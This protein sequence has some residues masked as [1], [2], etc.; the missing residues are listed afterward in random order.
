[1][2]VNKANL[3]TI[4]DNTSLQTPVV[5]EYSQEM[6]HCAQDPEYTPCNGTTPLVIPARPTVASGALPENRTRKR[7]HGTFVYD[8]DTES[9]VTSASD[10]EALFSDDELASLL[11]PPRPPHPTDYIPDTLE[12]STL[13][14]L[15]PPSYATSRASKRLSTDLASIIKFQSSTAPHELGFHVLPEVENLYQWIV[16]LHS[17]PHSLP[18]TQDMAASSPPLRSIVAEV[19]FGPDY[20]LEPPFVRI[21]RPRFR[22]FMLGGG[23]NVTAGGAMCMELLTTSGWSA[24]FT[25]ESVLMQVR[26]ALCDEE[27]P[28]RLL[29]EPGSYDKGEA[30]E[31]YLRACRAHGWGVPHGL[32]GWLR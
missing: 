30:V 26:L 28:A 29:G 13:P 1:V 3:R 22:P 12:L 25:V 20:P 16:E 31:A 14:I 5:P 32:A 6:A 23:G 27:R 15:P 17:F 4:L 8:S 11:P 21:I 19:R 24:A 18:L 7:R 2:Y 9:I 10:R